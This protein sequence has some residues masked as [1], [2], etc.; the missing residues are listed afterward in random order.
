MRELRDVRMPMRDGTILYADVYLPEREGR[1]PTLL[2]RT[3]Y[4]K[5]TSSEITL[6]SPKVYTEHGYAVVIQDVR[7]RFKSEGEFY[8]FRDDGWGINRDGYDSVEWIAAQDWCAG[9]VGTIGGSYSGVTQYRMLPMRPPHL[10]AQFVR[11]SSS[12]YHREWTYRGGALELG[13]AAHWAMRVTMSNLPHLAKEADIPAIR[14]R[15]EA[16]D[17]EIHQWLAQRPQ[18]P[19]PLISGLSEWFNDWLAHPNEDAYWWDTTIALHHHEVD[20]PVW[21]LGGWFDSFLRGTLVN[22]EGM[23]ARGMPN[24]RRS[25]KLIVGPWIHGPANIAKRVVGEVDYGQAASV[26]IHELR[27]PWFDHWLKG[28]QNGIM[29]EPPVRVFTMGANEWQSLPAWP[30]PDVRYEDWYFQGAKSGSAASPND[31]S[32]AVELPPVA[33]SPDSY[34]Y[35]PDD[36][37]PAYG[38]GWLSYAEDRTGGYDQ[39]PIEGRVLTYTS[40]PLP[41]DLEVTGWI[42]AR[43]FAMSSAPDT[44]FV[45][46]LTDVAPD[47]TSRIVADG[48][49][50]ARYRESLERPSLLT[51]NKV[52]EMEVD[53][54]ASSNLFRAGH[55]LRVHVTSSCWPRWDA[56]PNTGDPLFESARGQA[57]LNTVFHDAFRPSRISLPVRPR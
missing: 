56:N 12:D 57:A 52:E 48:V 27:L 54:W 19:S 38:G 7:G 15:L 46:R 4:N 9:K 14:G 50:R 3:P 55:R 49:L 45:V 20:T 8:P 41:R 35:D 40:T 51:P 31:G 53:L 13:F 28:E 18:Y 25:Q 30:P 42:K 44:D 47:G 26:D 33:D 17:K 10:A 1:F 6:G 34:Q 37:I 11:E 21:H 36:P 43:L 16:A 23:V 24:A 39:R 5:E 2:E 22:Y 29:D 32:L